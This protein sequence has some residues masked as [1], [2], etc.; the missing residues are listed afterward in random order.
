MII[1]VGRR[2]IHNEIYTPRAGLPLSRFFPGFPGFLY[3]SS[4]F[5]CG[6]GF[7]RPK[8]RDF[9]TKVTRN[10]VFFQK[11]GFRPRTVIPKNRGIKEALVYG[12]PVYLQFF[13]IFEFGSQYI[14][15]RILFFPGSFCLD[16]LFSFFFLIFFFF[17]TRV[18]FGFFFSFFLLGFPAYFTCEHSR[19]QF[20]NSPVVS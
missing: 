10:P 1:I 19:T 5:I 9:W 13:W 6:L 16:P 15:L 8:N 2:L 7:I 14:Y 18:R 12:A 20:C 3:C 17:F 4:R 11:L